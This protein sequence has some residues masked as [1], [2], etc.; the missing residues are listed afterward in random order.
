MT[1]DPAEPVDRSR[2]VL[3]KA[4]SAGL[5][6]SPVVAAGTL[7][8]PRRA[9]AQGAA[10]N[11]LSPDEVRTLEAFGEA[12]LPGAA[13]AGIAHYVDAQL[14]ASADACKLI[15]RYFDLPFPYTGFYAGALAAVDG[16]SRSGHDTAFAELEVAAARELVRSLNAEVPDGWEGPP[17]GLVYLVLRADAIDVVYGTMEGYEALGIPYMAHI[18]PGE[19]W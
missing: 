18:P 19:R 12:V 10:M 4:T 6:A 16:L 13:E 3:L 1:T 15:A 9:K 5:L 17:A 14:H 2:R 7:L 8:T 11:V